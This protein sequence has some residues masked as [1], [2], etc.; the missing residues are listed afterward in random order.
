MWLLIE[1]GSYS[2]AALLISDWLMKAARQIFD[3]LHAIMATSTD[4]I[5]GYYSRV[6]IIL[7]LLLSSSG[8]RQIHRQTH[9]LTTVTLAH[10]VGGL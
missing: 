10:A 3:S 9:K 8:N 4:C 6:V 2:R 5:R 1:G 7:F